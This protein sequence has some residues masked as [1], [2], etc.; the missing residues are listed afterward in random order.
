MRLVDFRNHM[1]R[2]L[3]TQHRD[4]TPN[5]EQNVLTSA[6]LTQIILLE[7]IKLAIASCFEPSND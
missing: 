4:I 6:I 2:S 5:V 3:F 7:F 1:S